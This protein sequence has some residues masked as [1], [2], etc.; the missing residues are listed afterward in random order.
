MQCHKWLFDNPRILH[1]DINANNIMYRLNRKGA[2]C[3]V[4]NDFDMSCYREDIVNGLPPVYL[5]NTGTLPYMALDRSHV[6]KLHSTFHFYCHDLESFFYVMLLF[7]SRHVLLDDPVKRASGP[8]QRYGVFPDAPF[9]EWYDEDDDYLRGKK[10][11]LL[12]GDFDAETVSSSF[13]NFAPWL[14]RLHGLIRQGLQAAQNA[15]RCGRICCFIKSFGRKSMWR[16]S[17][18]SFWTMMIYRRRI[19]WKRD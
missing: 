10:R 13:S 8:P 5:R 12:L 2:I 4:L 11:Q 16:V 17:M 18:Q 3:G 14:V 1:R 7:A 19:W 15:R 9:E 6:N